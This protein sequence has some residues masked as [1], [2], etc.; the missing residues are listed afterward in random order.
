MKKILLFGLIFGVLLLVGTT[1]FIVLP[2]GDIILEN[3]ELASLTNQQIANY[4]ANN[5]DLV[6][7]TLHN[8]KVIVMYN[9]TYLEPL[10]DEDNSFRVFKQHKPFIIS[11]ELL[12]L[13]LNQTTIEVC[14]EFLIHRETPFTYVLNETNITIE[15]TY[16]QAREEQIRLYHKAIEFRDTAIE[17]EMGGFFNIIE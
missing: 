13:C 9:L 12:L 6:S 16:Y 8:G 11:R 4:M 3:N 10:Q 14:E 7:K 17:N 15:S 5:F 2:N 1:A